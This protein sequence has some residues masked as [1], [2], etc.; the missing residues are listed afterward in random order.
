M[1]GM[2]WLRG[3]ACVLALGG[4]ARAAGKVTA[5]LE[6][7]VVFLDPH[8]TT[9]NISRTFGYMVFDTLFSMDS[10]GKIQPQMVAATSVSADGLTYNF[11]LRA[12]LAFHD[13]APVTAGD[14]VASLKRW[15]PRDALGRMLFAATSSLEAVGTDTVVLKLRE[16]FP[17]VLETLGKPNA[18]VPFIMP[19]RLA[20]L[21]S[22]QKFTDVVGSGPFRYRA[23]L[24]RAGDTMTVE[25]NPG[26]VPRV[27]APDFLAGGKRVK[28]DRVVMRVMPDASTGVAALLAGEIDYL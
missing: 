17:L 20:R 19:E 4:A 28:V 25:R 16:R 10:Q 8:F 5:V 13:G 3:V 22:D 27:E 6:S 12:G 7:E 23:D 14:V 11:T 26:Y 1:N 15:G 21:P 2:H 18:L 24:Y 9:A